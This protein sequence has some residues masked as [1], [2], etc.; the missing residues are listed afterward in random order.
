[1]ANDRSSSGGAPTTTIE[2]LVVVRPI[3]VIA[4][5]L[6]ALA[7]L[8][9]ILSVAATTW[10]E[11][12]RVTEGLWE[13]CRYRLEEEDM[14]D[15]EINPSR[16]WLQACRGLCMV[17]MI[18][19]F[20]GI[21]V[22][23]VGLRSSDYRSKYR[24]YVAGMVIWFCAVGIQLIA[25]V[26]FPIKFLDE[27]TDRAEA[28][29]Q[30]GWAYGIGWGAAIFDFIAGLLLLIDK[31]AEEVIYREVTVKNKEGFEEEATEPV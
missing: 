10:L 17:A 14:V 9:M 18:L 16:D 25:L 24:Y 13:K 23:S 12:N 1:M 6:A 21:V 28:R 15:C 8:L 3:K 5:I 27:I 19:T 30:F 11:A 26:T 31:G 20:V 4:V 7:M 22:T 29:W 2:T